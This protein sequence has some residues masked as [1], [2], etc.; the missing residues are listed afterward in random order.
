MLLELFVQVFADADVLE[1]PL[2]LGRVL[3]A[4]RLLFNDKEDR[5]GCRPAPLRACSVC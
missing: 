3:K 4:A 1:H 2:Q 5:L